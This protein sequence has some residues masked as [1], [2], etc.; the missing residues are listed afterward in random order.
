LSK[1]EVRSAIEALAP[2]WE[3]LADGTGASPFMH[4]GW[5]DAW[6]RSFGAG[7]PAV[8]ALRRDDGLAAVLPLYRRRGQLRSMTN[9]HTP[10]FGVLARDEAARVELLE[11]LVTTQRAPLTMAFLTTE[12][13]DPEAAR[14]VAEAAGVR[15]LAREIE[16]SPYV[17]IDGDWE[18]YRQGRDHKR[19]T[20]SRRRR[21]RLAEQGR[22]WLDVQD[23]TERLDALL[24][25]AF[26][27]EA[28]GW[29]SEQG[30]AIASR[31][32][33]REFYTRVAR[34]A[35]ARGWL[36]LAFLRLDERPLAVQLLIQA[37]GVA[38]QLK[39]GFDEGYRKFSP[40]MLLAE[41]VLERAFAEGLRS[42]EFLGDEDEFKSEWARDVRVRMTVQAFPPTAAGTAGWAAWAFGRPV[43]LR[44]RRLRAA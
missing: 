37:D 34:W 32:D 33:T 40:G 5:F 11:A 22:L 41:D 16:R 6:W 20:E 21:R 14:G 9:W 3:A 26:R 2:E 44:L 8:F 42:Y 10:E 31:A 27:V 24:D 15:V 17:P 7:R 36:R 25:E 38:S 30:T 35:A 23:G 1:V 12:R 39:G 19:M 43:A 28:S 29:K 18:R 4:P 13:P